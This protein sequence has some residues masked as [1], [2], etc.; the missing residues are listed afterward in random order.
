M[1]TKQ[2]WNEKFPPDH[3]VN[4]RSRNLAVSRSVERGLSR[5][6]LQTELVQ[7]S[8]QNGLRKVY[9]LPGVYFL[10]RF[11]LKMG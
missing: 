11:I 7:G 1:Y 5:Y 2:I 9:G 6:L 10:D 3:N 8:F 4:T